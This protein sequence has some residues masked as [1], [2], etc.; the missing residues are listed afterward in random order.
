M[1]DLASVAIA[2]PSESVDRFNA[3]LPPGDG[4]C[5]VV[6][7]AM[8]ARRLGDRRH[9]GALTGAG[10][11]D[12]T[13]VL[14]HDAARPALTADLVATVVSAAREVNGAVVPV[15]PVVDYL[16][17]VR[18]DRVVAPVDREEVAAAQTPKPR[19]SAPAR[20]NRGV[21]RLGPTDHR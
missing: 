14:V 12:E 1:R 20:G 11:D 6:P 18:G 21:A 17:R 8:R 19:G 10:H 3:A 4:R 13:L 16:K 5:I 15:V 7:G 9:L 2:V